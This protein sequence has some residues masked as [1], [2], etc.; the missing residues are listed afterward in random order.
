MSS[1]SFTDVTPNLVCADVQRSVE[2]Y[3]EFLGFSVTASVPE[4]APHAFVWLQRDGVN[5]FLNA[6]DAVRQEYPDIARRQLGGTG[7]LFITMTGIEPFYEAIKER[8]AVDT[9]LHTTWY[10]MHEFVVQDPDGYVITFA[11]RAANPAS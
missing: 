8:V 7:M 5:V 10:G 6:L 4:T 11:E 2:F 1:I 9:A 3:R